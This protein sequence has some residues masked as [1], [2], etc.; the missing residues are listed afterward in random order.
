MVIVL[1]CELF[2]LYGFIKS[3]LVIICDII[4]VYFLF[5]FLVGDNYFG[6]I[7]LVDEKIK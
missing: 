1:I 4:Y 5:F 3:I 7:L 2:I 6:V